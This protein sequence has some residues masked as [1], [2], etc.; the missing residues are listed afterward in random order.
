MTFREAE[1]R[2]DKCGDGIC[3][4]EAVFCAKCV[5]LLKN[6]IK[7]LVEDNQRLLAENQALQTELLEKENQP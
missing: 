6:H 5:E 1:I 4:G 3:D 2:C 7:V